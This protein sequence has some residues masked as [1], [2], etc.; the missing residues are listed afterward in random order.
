MTY[1]EL[2]LEFYFEY[3]DRNG[4]ICATPVELY[5]DICVLAKERGDEEVVW[6]DM[7]QYLKDKDYNDFC[8]EDV[9]I[10]FKR[11]KKE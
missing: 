9:H 8:I 11:G 1:K 2:E 5:K 7:V 10:C 3:A 4:V 6:N